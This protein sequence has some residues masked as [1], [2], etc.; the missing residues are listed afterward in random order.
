MILKL[1]WK[2]IWRNKTRSL[3]LISA[4][5]L[6][7]W[8]GL[9]MISFSL[10]MSD[11]RARDQIELQISHLQLHHPDFP[12]ERKLSYTLP[13]GMSVLTEIQQQPKVVAATGRSLGTGMLASPRKTVGVVINGVIPESEGLV[14][15]L[16]K[17]IVEG[18]YFPETRGKSILLSKRSAAM[19]KVKIRSKITLTTQNADGNMAA[20][21]FRVAGLFETID[22][23]YDE[24]NVFVRLADMQ[25]MVGQAG[26]IHEIAV[27]MADKDDVDSLQ[28]ALIDA[29]P[30]ML[31]QNWK[32]VSPELRMMVESMD[33][34]IWIFVGIIVIGLFFGIIN[35]MLMAVLERSGETGMLMAIGMSKRRVFS[36]IILESILLSLVGVPL[37][38]LA[39]EI[40]VG[41]F[42][43]Y[44]ID[45]SAFSEGLSQMGMSSRVYLS[46]EPRYYLLVTVNI[47][48][49]AFVAS[50]YPGFKALGMKGAAGK[51]LLVFLASMLLTPVGGL[52]LTY[53]F[54]PKVSYTSMAENLSRG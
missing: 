48:L 38:I 12:N 25:Q 13:E 29:Y 28:S 46:M 31:V 7:L 53:F 41:I 5:A 11:Q 9:A 47:L 36:L 21:A 17:K 16:D 45:M 33:Q 42:G 19:L 2:N 54:I 27:L 32:E 30:N 35:T 50:L 4:V 39:T 10:G 52:L 24:R 18:A 34:V 40:T 51:F 22:S 3:V 23:K 6:G 15:Q 20:E 49:A 44:G 43:T 14:T 1:A 8:G 26:E 37:G